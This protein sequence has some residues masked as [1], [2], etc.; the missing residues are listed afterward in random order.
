M[1][2]RLLNLL[3]RLRGQAARRIPQLTAKI[4]HVRETLL[5]GLGLDL[6]HRQ[7]VRY[8]ILIRVDVPREFTTGLVQLSLLRTAGGYRANQIQ[9]DS[10]ATRA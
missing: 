2:V 5:E 6:L 7:H 9:Y 3:A 1:R 8:S 10:R 4:R